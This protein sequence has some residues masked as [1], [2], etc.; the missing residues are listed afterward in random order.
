MFI[1]DKVFEISRL[2]LKY[3]KEKDFL[4]CYQIHI[5]H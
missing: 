5:F 1:A 4:A 2:D 3:H